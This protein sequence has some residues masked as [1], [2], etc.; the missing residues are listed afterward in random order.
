L[1]FKLEIKG[2]TTLWILTA[3][4]ALVGT[5]TVYSAS[6]NLAFSGGGSTFVDLAKHLFFIVAGFA[7]MYAVHRVDYN[8]FGSFSRL[9]LLPVAILLVYTLLNGVNVSNASRWIRLPLG[10][11]FQ[12]SA[13]ASVV[14]ITY[15]SRYLALRSKEE[16]R[17]FKATFLPLIFPILLVV[18]LILP[19]NFSTAALIFG[20]SFLLLFIGGYALKNLLILGGS[21]LIALALFV[22]VVY[23]FPNMSNRVATWKTRIESFQSGNSAENYQVTKAKMAI[24]EGQYLGKG[25]GK[26]ALKNFLPQSNSDFI[27]AVIVEE[28]GTIGGGLIIV[29]FIWILFRFLRIA[30]QAKTSFGSLLSLGLGLVILAQALVNLSVAV[31]LIPVTG[32]TLPLV[33]KGGTSIWMTAI[34]LGMVQSVSRGKSK[35]ASSLD[36]EALNAEKTDE[37]N[38][39]LNP[40]NLSHA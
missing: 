34:A 30:N 6:S 23:A 26:S 14:L 28:W 15:L 21:G 33:S 9:L 27:F 3:I 16:L 32:Q 24:A 8:L 17:S 29:V 5:I 35:S 10:Q 22:S 25:P 38:E 37:E 20:V 40:E 36:D 1:S 13:L 11:T 4:L 18:G 19:A 7:I 39:S 12:T 31:N 2:D